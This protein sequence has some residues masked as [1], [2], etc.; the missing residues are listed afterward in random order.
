MVLPLFKPM[1][2][3]WHGFAGCIKNIRLIL[4]TLINLFPGLLFIPSNL[5]SVPFSNGSR[6]Y[7]RSE[8][9]MEPHGIFQK[10]T[11]ATQNLNHKYG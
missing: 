10:I 6:D 3:N 4:S 8:F 9:I 2:I 7:G 11:Q 1:H 5:F